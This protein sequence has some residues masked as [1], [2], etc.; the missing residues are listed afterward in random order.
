MISLTQLVSDKKKNDKALQ[1]AHSWQFRASMQSKEGWL[2]NLHRDLNK[3][4]IKALDGSSLTDSQKKEREERRRKILSTIEMM[5]KSISYTN[6]FEKETV[7]ANAKHHDPLDVVEDYSVLE[8]QVT[9]GKE[10]GAKRKRLIQKNLKANQS[11]LHPAAHK[12]SMSK[13][14]IKDQSFPIPVHDTLLHTFLSLDQLDSKH[15]TYSDLL[16]NSALVDIQGKAY[17]SA[18]SKFEKAII[19]DSCHYPSLFNRAHLFI[20]IGKPGKA[21]DDFKC[22]TKIKPNDPVAYYNIGVIYNMNAK[23]SVASK[24]FKKSHDLDTQVSKYLHNYA[25]SLRRSGQYQVARREY[26]KLREHYRRDTAEE[27][28]KSIYDRIVKDR[29][30]KNKYLPDKN[31]VLKKHFEYGTIEARKFIRECYVKGE[32]DN[33]ERNIAKETAILSLLNKDHSLFPMSDYKLEDRPV[34]L[35]PY[36]EKG[37]MAEKLNEDDG[38]QSILQELLSTPPDERDEGDIDLIMKYMPY[39]DFFDRFPQKLKRKLFKLITYKI[40]GAGTKICKEGEMPTKLNIVWSGKVFLQ[41]E[42]FHKFDSRIMTVGSI[43][44]GKSVCEMELVRNIPYRNSAVASTDVE[45]FT[46]TALGYNI[47]I[48]RFDEGDVAN[49]ADIIRE[50]RIFNSWSDKAFSRIATLS[51]S[52]F[53]NTGDVIINQGITADEIFIMRRGL[54]VALHRESFEGKEY[55]IVVTKLCPGDVFGER[56]I[57]DPINGKYRFSIKCDTRVEVLV[58]GK[59]MIPVAKVTHAVRDMID[60]QCIRKFGRQ[61]A[62]QAI[63]DL[64]IHETN[65]K[66]VLHKLSYIGSDTY[67]KGSTDYKAPA[68]QKK[69][70]WLPVNAPPLK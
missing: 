12:V 13:L 55:D 2:A 31:S 18:M 58:L 47:T 9:L 69:R 44:D 14:S 21:I 50:A 59:E 15:V 35:N 23:H 62:I 30:L 6:A 3:S 33:Y 11:K 5:D 36:L 64:K 24:Y 56:S 25:L 48:K 46:L 20:I 61:T 40:V 16:H 29:K 37:F 53:Y 67:K 17:R 57:I 1:A 49:K 54:A 27:I 22:C 66:K 7:P 4:S 38:G 63:A 41:R 28:R 51:R 65:R 43:N 60:E 8:T 68:W 39:I 26:R 45:L 32:D 10:A 34:Y 42:I 19:A 52:R 70:P